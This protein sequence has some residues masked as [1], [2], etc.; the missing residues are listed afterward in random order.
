[1]YTI[2]HVVRTI[3]V[4]RGIA[5]QSTSVGGNRQ[6]SIQ[7]DS[8][9]GYMFVATDGSHDV[10]VV[11]LS[12]PTYDILPATLNVGGTTTGTQDAVIDFQDGWLVATRNGVVD[13]G[14]FDGSGTITMK[15]RDTDL[16]VHYCICKFSGSSYMLVGETSKAFKYDTNVAGPIADTG[17]IFLSADIIYAREISTDYVII[18]STTEKANF[19]N[20]ASF[21]SDNDIYVAFRGGSDGLVA[22]PTG[23]RFWDRYKG[24][25]RAFTFSGSNYWQGAT[26]AISANGIELMKTYS[27]ILVISGSNIN[28]YDMISLNPVTWGNTPPTVGNIA[29][30]SLSRHFF[31]DVHNAGGYVFG[32]F[33][34]NNQIVVGVFKP[35]CM[36]TNCDVC[37][38]D[39]T[40]YCEKCR[41]SP[42][43]PLPSIQYYLK[44]ESTLIHE[45]IDYPNIPAQ[46]G[47]NNAS[48]KINWIEKCS[49]TN[50]SN[51]RDLYTDCKLC[52]PTW[53]VYEKGC[54]QKPQFPI[55]TGVNLT[56]LYVE[57]CIDPGC[58]DCTDDITVCLA[59]KTDHYLYTSF[60]LTKEN[61]PLRKGVRT[62]DNSVQDCFDSRC[63][64]C[65]DDIS[66]C[67]VCQPGYYLYMNTCID[68]PSFPQS[69]GIQGIGVSPCVD[70]NCSDCKMSVS[71]CQV[72]NTGWYTFEGS[73]MQKVDFM[74]YQG[75]STGSYSVVNCTD[76]HCADCKDDY[77][78]CVLCDQT[79]TGS[80]YY[81]AATPNQCM[82]KTQLLSLV[83]P[84]GI[85]LT[86]GSIKTNPCGDGNCMNCIDDHTTCVSCDTP[87]GYYLNLNTS[88]CI[89]KI[90]FPLS[91]GVDLSD[92]T[93]KPCQVANCASCINDMNICECDNVNG[94]YWYNNQCIMKDAFPVGYG[95]NTGSMK[96]EPCLDSQCSNC[97]D[98]LQQCAK[99]T[100]TST[101]PYLYQSKCIS[102]GQVPNGYGANTSTNS[103]E[104][105]T[106][107]TNCKICDVDKTI[108]TRCEQN[109]AN[110]YLL[111]NKCIP[112]QDIPKGMGPDSFGVLSACSKSNCSLCDTDKTT[113]QACDN[114]YYLFPEK[115]ECFEF[116]KIPDFYGI[117]GNTIVTCNDDTCLDCRVNAFKC[118][119][120]YQS[121]LE[122]S[123][124][125]KGVVDYDLMYTIRLKKEGL[126]RTATSD[127]ETN[128]QILQKYFQRVMNST[129]VR[130]VTVITGSKMQS[131]DIKITYQ[132][133]KDFSIRIIVK[134]M[135]PLELEYRIE[136]DIDEI[137]YWYF[138]VTYG[139]RPVKR[140][141]D[142]VV[143][144]EPYE[145]GLM[146]PGQTYL[147]DPS[148]LIPIG[149]PS[150]KNNLMVMIYAVVSIIASNLMLVKFGQFIK[151]LTK[152]QFIN[153]VFGSKLSAFLDTTTDSFR[154]PSQKDD[155][156][157]EVEESIGFKGK[158]SRKKITLNFFAI[159]K[160]KIV[161]YCVSLVLRV[162]LQVRYWTK[163]KPPKLVVILMYFFPK[164]HVIL[165][166][167]VILDFLFYG[168]RPMSHMKIGYNENKYI[169]SIVIVLLSID[170]F[171]LVYYACETPLW[172]TK[173]KKRVNEM[174]KQGLH[175]K[176]DEIDK[177]D[178][179]EQD[180]L[181]DKTVVIDE[182]FKKTHNY[183]YFSENPEEGYEYGLDYEKSY[184]LITHCNFYIEV[185]EIP[186]ARDKKVY[187]S[188]LPRLHVV[189]G[190]IRACLYQLFIMCG[191]HVSTSLITVLMAV[192]A[193]KMAYHVYTYKKYRY[194]AS[195]F[196]FIGEVLQSVFL[197][198]FFVICLF[199]HI[200][201]LPTEV[202]VKYQTIGIYLVISAVSTEYLLLIFNGLAGAVKGSKEGKIKKKYEKKIKEAEK[203]KMSEWTKLEKIIHEKNLKGGLPYRRIDMSYMKE[204]RF[205][206][207]IDE[208]EWNKHIQRKRIQKKYYFSGKTLEEIEAERPKFYQINPDVNEVEDIEEK[209]VGNKRIEHDDNLSSTINITKNPTI[210]VNSIES[211]RN[212][213]SQVYPESILSNKILPKPNKI[214]KVNQSL[215]QE[216]M[217]YMSVTRFRSQSK[218][219]EDQLKISRAIKT[220]KNNGEGESEIIEEEQ[221]YSYEL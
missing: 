90:S 144:A 208:E 32:Y 9:N 58:D 3:T 178:V 168:A 53:Y 200:G 104:Q 127:Y 103:I 194:L 120:F 191:Q 154:P 136:I 135:Q 93:V 176:P 81:V 118:V 92:N 83:I 192:E 36:V 54:L 61:F 71:T 201:D 195:V 14:Y 51:C 35:I 151:L 94:Y 109:G 22:D 202:H 34:G 60:C 197:I 7:I 73:C 187:L 160:D 173:Y 100:P 207:E 186:L 166:N 76:L 140:N 126:N 20:K 133:N 79:V 99:C 125:V 62:T 196:I 24:Y 181:H 95:I 134:L 106:S 11:N 55:W 137:T 108:C 219:L 163:G 39:P 65:K 221:G 142:K 131:S 210:M 69:H 188:V 74:K 67:V 12:S 13:I 37:A 26:A 107:D 165:L 203:K 169:S 18:E 214:S 156:R 75:V 96:V 119:V 40:K 88:A 21:N 46:Y 16:R 6:N 184:E 206:D 48:I 1:M 153:I 121:E 198:L 162:Y 5:Y 155:N 145:N 189:I 220:Q 98:D 47:I 177:L 212:R 117:Q 84:Q 78:I 150:L 80:E 112:R 101:N 50:C 183:K 68:P 218:R 25:L 114:G 57:V 147:F 113:C 146:F 42:K 19:I 139:M 158:I 77:T 2:I 174:R 123:N 149:S 193:C 72:C 82:L 172:S 211:N 17:F 199:I 49:D 124:G 217:N 182:E 105:C 152:I 64:Y 59:C 8:V 180:V 148:E 115:N 23:N 185:M 141:K 164:I 205:M 170:V 128:D 175:L 86:T 29:R 129:S 66:T 167:L 215:R 56:S 132:R 171:F 130:A 102:I 138:G 4:D 43:Y 190:L 70:T 41:Q 179:T 209:E 15:R 111:D 116:E 31:L 28:A 85:D 213:V 216:L 44:N 27:M 33:T 45:C 110:K 122:V 157:L 143:F 204:K 89:Q 10:R 38:T 161:I 159:L 91:H 52:N 87:S 63:Y 30:N 97:K